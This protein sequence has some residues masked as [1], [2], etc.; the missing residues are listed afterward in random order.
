MLVVTQLLEP[1]DP[2]TQPAT[3]IH[4]VTQDNM[5][6]HL[7]QATTKLASACKLVIDVKHTD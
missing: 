2:L 1:L 7:G 3:L 5:G 4:P 6:T